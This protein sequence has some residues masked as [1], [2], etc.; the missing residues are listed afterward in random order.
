[1]KMCGLERT[2]Y[3]YNRHME[4]K[5]HKTWVRVSDERGFE[6]KSYAAMAAAE[7]E[8]ESDRLQKEGTCSQSSTDVGAPF[9]KDIVKSFVCAGVPMN[10]LKHLRAF[11]QRNCNKSLG[12]YMHLNSYVPELTASETTLQ[13]AELK[14]ADVFGIIFDATPRQGDFFAM[15]ARRVVLHKGIKKAS[16]AQTLIHCAALKGSLNADTLAGQVTAGLA[17][18]GKKTKDAVVGM[19]D[20]CYTNGAAQDTTNHAAALSN[21]LQQFVSLC[22]S[23][24]SNNAGEKATAPTLEYFWSLLMKVF[25]TSEIAKV[26]Y[27]CLTH[28]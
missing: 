7:A 24:L 8:R 18:R 1:M 5:C 2:E 13:A 14:L 9:R 23:H 10:K 12:H 26:I 27:D 25:S 17:E 20:G 6:Q 16:C 15:I 11:L 28:T 21:D 19:M 22:M 3:D 4:K